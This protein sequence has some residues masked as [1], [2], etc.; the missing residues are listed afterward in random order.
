M[1][2][3]LN[4][5]TKPLH[6]GIAE[7]RLEPRAAARRAGCG[8]AAKS[9]RIKAAFFSRRHPFTCRSTA[10]ASSSRSKYWWNTNSTGRLTAV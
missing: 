3:F 2:G 7:V 1:T 8:K 6:G 9:P 4:A 5:I 10:A